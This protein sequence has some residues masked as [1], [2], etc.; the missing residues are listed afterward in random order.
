MPG[1]MRAGGGIG[2]IL[3]ALLIWF[4]STQMGDST[5]T[6]TDTGASQSG[7][8]DSGSGALTEQC[9]TGEDANN[10]ADC[11]RVAVINSVQSFWA[12][13]LPEQAGREY[14]QADTQFFS[15][16]TTTACG[17]AT[18]A[19]GP[20]YCPA[21]SLVYL[22]TTFFDDMLEGQLGARGG[23]FSEAYVIAHEYGH[24]VQNLLGTMGQVRDREGATSDA[25]RLELQADCYAG[26]WAAAATS[27][28]DA[29]GDV[30]I[31]SDLT[32][33]D[34][35]RAIDAAE[36]VGDDRIQQRSG[37]QVDPETWTHGSSDQREAWFMAGY[38]ASDMRDCDTF[39]ISTL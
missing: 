11:A 17:G 26:M 13:T 23:P 10:N 4:V 39:G 27:A 24:H 28:T 32:Q 9:R 33:D 35:A 37:G 30:A 16:S 25:V 6:A 1:G 7:S 12:Q 31:I 19:V 14:Q 8:A 20:F 21:D 29:T 2:G 34:I 15:G 38:E 5:G 3:I 22:D 36:A 18:S